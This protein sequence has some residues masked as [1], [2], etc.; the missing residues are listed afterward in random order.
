MTD[1]REICLYL[2]IAFLRGFRVFLCLFYIFLFIKPLF[3]R[4]VR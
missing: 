1:N 2:Q 3:S 4:D